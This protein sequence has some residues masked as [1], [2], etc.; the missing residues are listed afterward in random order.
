[1]IRTESA[2]IQVKQQLVD[3]VDA[4]SYERM[5]QLLDFAAFLKQRSDIIP[6]SEQGTE[7]GS[8]N[9]WEE[10]LCNAEVYWFSLPEQ[11]RRTYEG[12]VVAL[13]KDQIVDSDQQLRTLK[14][15]VRKNLADQPVLYLEVDAELLPPLSIRSPKLR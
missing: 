3:A 1:M 9:A 15:R 8:H 14:Q 2:R 6:E 12:K 13:L 5:Q 4:L 10:S 11:V 7:D